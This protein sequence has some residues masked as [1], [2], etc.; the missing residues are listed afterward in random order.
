MATSIPNSHK[1][2]LEKPVVVTLVTVMP[3]GQ[4]QATPVW[5]DFDG[6]YVRINTARGR[7]KDKN[8]KE[9]GC[10]TILAV[11][12]QNPYRWMEIRGRVAHETEE[13]AVEHINA[14]S[15]KYRGVSD[16]YAGNPSMRGK[17]TRVTYVIEPTHVNAAG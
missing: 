1:D 15:A 5:C 14:L 16:Y 17:E 7:Q 4:P 13:N 3:D 12:P 10:A 9:R 2:L 6:K 11:D 8:L